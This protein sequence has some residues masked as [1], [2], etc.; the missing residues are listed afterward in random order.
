[1]Q[2][3]VKR[4]SCESARR[5]QN[6]SNEYIISVEPACA[7]FR[8][9]RWARGARDARVSHIRNAHVAFSPTT[10]FS[11]SLTL[12][13]IIWVIVYVNCVINVFRASG[14]K[15]CA[16][17]LTFYERQAVLVRRWRRR[18]QSSCPPQVGRASRVIAARP[19]QSYTHSPNATPTRAATNMTIHI[20][21]K[22]KSWFTAGRNESTV[23]VQK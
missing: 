7:S 1:M 14:I 19:A 21:Q 18:R 10:L 4:E 6:M 8:R 3:I 23:L 16:R 12:Q 15:V 13:I 11:N 9:R 20:E 22:L 2:L 17:T 5:K